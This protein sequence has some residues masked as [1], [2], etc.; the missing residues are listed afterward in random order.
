[1]S[2]QQTSIL[3]ESLPILIREGLSDH[4]AQKHTNQSPD[5]VVQKF[6]FDN[7]LKALTSSYREDISIDGDGSGN[8]YIYVRFKNTSKEAVNGFYIH[9]YR[10][11]L[12]LYNDPKDWSK[13]E[14]K[15]A[16]GQPVYIDSLKA[17]EIG[18]TPAFIYNSSQLGAHPNCFVAVATRERTPDYSSINSF[19][20]YVEWIDKPNVAARNVCVHQR[21][22]RHQSSSLSFRNP[23]TD[24]DAVLGFYATVQKG[25]SSGIRYGITHKELNIDI[26]KTYTVNDDNSGR[27]SWMGPVRAGYS[28]KL[29]LWYETLGNDHADIMCT[30][31]T[32]EDGLAQSRALFDRYGVDLTENFSGISMAIPAAMNTPG[33]ALVLGGCRIK[34]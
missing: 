18:A 28:G 34:N 8:M 33:R 14:M 24:H 25:T 3:N 5:I 31:F 1:M 16:S 29:T 23:Y 26:A 32:L 27:I 17:H 19:A 22:V 9:L 13:Y 4:G 30:Y 20:K 15:T 2:K 21:S 10:N 11:H 12:G 6:E 7:P